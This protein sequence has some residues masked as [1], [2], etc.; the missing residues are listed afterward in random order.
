MIGMIPYPLLIVSTIF[1]LNNTDQAAADMYFGFGF[2]NYPNRTV[3]P[4]DW[5]WLQWCCCH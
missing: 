2:D 1:G 3:V 5:G 4:T